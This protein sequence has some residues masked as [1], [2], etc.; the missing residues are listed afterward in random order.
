M[1]DTNV[2]KAIIYNQYKAKHNEVIC[3]FHEARG[4]SHWLDVET[5]SN[6]LFKYPNFLS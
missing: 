5:I 6:A 3:M 1:I 2:P 4:I